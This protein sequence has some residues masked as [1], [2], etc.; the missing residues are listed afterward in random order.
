VTLDAMGWAEFGPL[1]LQINVYNLTDKRY[2]ISGHGTSAL[3]N[4]PGAPRSVLGT[5]RISF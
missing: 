4:M 2:I 1:R 3:L 5:A